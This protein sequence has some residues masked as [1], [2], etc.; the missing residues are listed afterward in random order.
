MLISFD[1]MKIS[2]SQ[3]QT[4]F[5]DKLPTPE[6][7]V[8]AITFHAFEIESVE[9]DGD[10]FVLDIK[11]LPDR[12]CYAKSYEGIAREVSTILGLKKNSDKVKI[13]AGERSIVVSSAQINEVLG[14]EISSEEVISILDRMDITVKENGDKL[15]LSIPGDRLDL[16]SWRDIP[17]EVG[18]IYGYDKIKPILPK[19]TS[20]KPVVEKT[21]YYSEKI[22]NILVSAGF[23]EV[24]TYSLVA[25]GVFEI[26]KPLAADK[27]HLRTN[28]T[29]GIVESLEFNARNS[30]L[31]GLDEVKIFEIGKVFTKDGEH[32]SLCIGIK[33]IKKIKGA[34]QAKDKIKKVRD[35][36]FKI[37]NSSATIL[38]TVDDSGGIIS[39]DGEAIGMT[40]NS[41]GIF[42]VN[43]DKLIKTLDEPSSYADLDFGK[44]ASVEY[45][46]FSQYPFIVR[47]IAV[48]VQGPT[49]DSDNEVWQVIEKSITEAG[50]GDLI[51]RHSLF[52]TFK[53]EDKTSYAFRIVF[54]SMKKTLTDGEVNPVMERVYDQMR[55]NGWEVR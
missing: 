3:L 53:K 13:P 50:A 19:N 55:E 8:E 41:D 32:T 49:S 1:T 30:D 46:K 29:D 7:L 2:Y 44:S 10:D 18:R 25:K 48:F 15:E 11:V 40:N 22:K 34:D 6:K 28:L 33:N 16:Q 9:K 36:I 39:V 31:L 27:N 35:E 51:A 24:Y 5:E 23:S 20:F 43:L 45:K 17:E 12:A 54:Q 26:E 38:C 37:I 47:D 42:E 52:D 14:S 4:Y 21:F